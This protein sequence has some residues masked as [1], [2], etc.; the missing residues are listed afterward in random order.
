MLMEKV[1]RAPCLSQLLRGHSGSD[2][3]SRSSQTGKEKAIKD[4]EAT[5]KKAE[6]VF[7]SGYVMGSMWSMCKD[8]Q[9]C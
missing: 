5:Q 9:Q 7:L 6:A 3:R 4:A 2:S 1:I 8:G